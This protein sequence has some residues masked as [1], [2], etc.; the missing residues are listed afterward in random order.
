MQEGNGNSVV[1]KNKK[2]RHFHTKVI[3]VFLGGKKGFDGKVR[4]EDRGR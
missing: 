1:H 3:R 2:R 4:E